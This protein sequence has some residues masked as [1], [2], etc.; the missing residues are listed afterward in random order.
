MSA[1]RTTINPKQ[2]SDEDKTTFPRVQY[3]DHRPETNDLSCL[4]QYWGTHT[5]HKHGDICICTTTLLPYRSPELVLQV[6]SLFC[7]DVFR[8]D[9]DWPYWMPG[10]SV[11]QPDQRVPSRRHLS[12]RTRPT[13]ASTLLHEHA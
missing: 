3:T 9:A 10:R 11:M 13:D 6:Q 2:S 5:R 1:C 8:E 7:E 12:M 4:E